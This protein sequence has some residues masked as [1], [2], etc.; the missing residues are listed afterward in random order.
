MVVECQTVAAVY[1]I[2]ER[3]RLGS[4]CAEYKSGARVLSIA[5]LWANQPVDEE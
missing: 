3:C 4:M 5:V 1:P 2:T